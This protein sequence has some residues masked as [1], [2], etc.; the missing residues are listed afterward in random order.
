MTKTNEILLEVEITWES[1]KECV[2]EAIEIGADVQEFTGSLLDSYII[3]GSNLNFNGVD[4]KYVI[5]KENFVNTQA[6]NILAI[7]TDSYELKEEHR[8]MLSFEYNKT[9]ENL[10]ELKEEYISEL[11]P[12]NVQISMLYFLNAIE[13]E[14]EYLHSEN[15]LEELVDIG[16]LDKD[17]LQDLVVEAYDS[18]EAY[19]ESVRPLRELLEE[20]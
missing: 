7:V 6:S 16:Y 17:D 13:M 10:K 9:M 3:E 5:F 19:L 15:D 4:G 18:E 8:N 20:A 2:N 1:A 12:T 14:L 11:E